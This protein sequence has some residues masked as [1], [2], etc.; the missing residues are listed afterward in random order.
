M[1]KVLPPL[2][3]RWKEAAESFPGRR[4][5]RA[6]MTPE[7]LKVISVGRIIREGSTMLKFKLLRQAIC[8]LSFAALLMLYTLWKNPNAKRCWHDD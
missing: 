3:L 2:P 4:R 1:P 5:G 6:A 7:L 8:A